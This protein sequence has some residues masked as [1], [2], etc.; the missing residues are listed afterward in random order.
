MAIVTVT[1]TTTFLDWRTRTNEIITKLNN[2]EDLADVTDTINVEA[3]GALM[4][5]ELAGEAAVKATTAA[6]LLADETK[7]DAIEA[8]AD[9]TDTANVTAAGAVMDSPSSALVSFVIDEDTMAANSDTKVPTQQSVRAYV[10]TQVA[11]S[12]T[13]EMSYKG[14]YDASLNVPNLD[15]ASPIVTD[16]GDMYTVTVAGT[17]FSI[18]L[19]V[20]DVLISEKIG[21]SVEADWTIVN[22][23][24]DADSILS[25]L[26]TVDI[27]AS[28]LNATT[29]QGNTPSAFATAG[30]IHTTFDRASSVLA[31][32]TIFSNLTVTDGI[33][34]AI[35]TRELTPA[36]I[37]ASAT[38][39]THSAFARASSVLSGTNVFSNLT[40]TNGIVTAIATRAMTLGNFGITATAAEVNYTTD[41]TSNIQAQLNGKSATSHQHTSYD[42][43]A[44]SLGG[45][46]V[47]SNIDVTNGITTLIQTRNLTLANLGYTGETNATADQT[48][49]QLLASLKTVDGNGTGGLNAGT[50]DGVVSTSFARL[51][52]PAFTGTPTAPTQA[53][54]NNTTRIA[55][56]AFVQNQPATLPDAN[57]ITQAHIAANAVGQSE[58]KTTTA[59][60]SSTIPNDSFA[61]ISPTGGQHSLNVFVDA[62]S[63]GDVRAYGTGTLHGSSTSIGFKNPSKTS[64]TGY[65]YSR[66][67]QASPPY[68]LG[69]GDIPL[70]IYVVVDNLTGAAEGISVATDPHWAYN[71]GVLLVPDR[72]DKFGKKF[73]NVPQFVAESFD[74]K[75][76]LMSGDPILRQEALDMLENKNTGEVEI[77]HDYQNQTMNVAPHCWME[78]DLTGKTVVL[79]DPTSPM[80]LDL[81]EIHKQNSYNNDIEGS[82][83]NLIENQYILFDNTP[84]ARTNPEGIISIKPRWKNTL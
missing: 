69:D 81:Y 35:A 28:G 47:Y 77:T 37:G 18:P 43:N 65:L 21:S 84:L 73:K 80:V 39:H 48:A 7:L 31:G 6:F 33:V 56:T 30:H 68:N 82:V 59:N 13:S 32:A 83:L 67:V 5:S 40:V 44:A 38:N 66:Y 41:V 78:N 62:S 74:I 46:T 55:T 20:G 53:T 16:S 75:S 23:N 71:G 4:D 76:A 57:T 52:S 63:V 3:A 29:L 42:Y 22:K 72:V 64:G 36:N 9:V 2:V 58:L 10:D 8:L 70:F 79:L 54:A 25:L 61:S 24:L 51:A 12:I 26:L 17:F 11:F 34:T 19:E 50:F 14:S 27:D 49:A 1:P 15:A 60:Q 45:A